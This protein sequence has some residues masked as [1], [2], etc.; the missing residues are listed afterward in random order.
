MTDDEFLKLL[1]PADFVVYHHLGFNFISD[2]I[3]WFTSSISGKRRASHVDLYAGCGEVIGYTIG[4]CKWN[5]L[6]RYDNVEMTIMRSKRNL[7]MAEQ[8]LVCQRAEK[9]IG[10]RTYDYIAYA[11]FLWMCLKHKLGFKNV[12]RKDNPLQGAGDVCSTGGD[13]WYKESILMD[14]FGYLGDESVTPAHYLVCPN[15]VEVGTYRR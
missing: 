7:T 3:E 6:F 4:G 13:P 1:Q 10:V 12:F 5:N 9:D 2:G 8:N 15:L 14:L 11:G